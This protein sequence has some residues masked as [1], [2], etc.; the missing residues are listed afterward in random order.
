LEKGVVLYGANALSLLPVVL[1]VLFVIFCITYKFSCV[2]FF[3][4]LFYWLSLLYVYDMVQCNKP[5]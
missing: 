5:V 3:S 4:L 1:F 2:T